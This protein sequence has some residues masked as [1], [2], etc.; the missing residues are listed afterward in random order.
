MAARRDEDAQTMRAQPL[1]TCRFNVTSTTGDEAPDDAEGG[2]ANAPTMRRQQW[3]GGGH[4]DTRAD[5][6]QVLNGGQSGNTGESAEG[7]HKADGHANNPRACA[8]DSV[9]TEPEDAC[10]EANASSVIEQRKAHACLEANASSV[11]EQRKAHECPE[12]NA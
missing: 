11:I 7:A 10:L 1:Q 4:P 3:H 6:G 2:K 12:A 5:D 9:L 8:N